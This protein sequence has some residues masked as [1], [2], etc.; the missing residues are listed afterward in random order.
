MEILWNSLLKSADYLHSKS[1]LI[2]KNY[3]NME[4]IDLF[5]K[6]L[7]FVKILSQA[8]RRK[9]GQEFRSLEVRE[10]SL[11]HL[12]MKINLNFSLMTNNEIPRLSV[13]CINGI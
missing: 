9:E 1:Q 7:V 11:L 2:T 10:A 12:K 4:G 6:V 3:L 5:V 13:L 8:R